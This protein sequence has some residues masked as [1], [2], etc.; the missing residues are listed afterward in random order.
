MG[1]VL[2]EA[3]PGLGLQSKMASHPQNKTPMV[4]E[5]KRGAYLTNTRI[6]DLHMPGGG[7]GDVPGERSD[8][9]KG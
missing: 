4:N 1:W 6:I 2:Q 3:I 7:E 5:R 9:I 8:Q